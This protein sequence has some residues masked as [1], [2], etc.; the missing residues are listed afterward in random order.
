MRR[1][2]PSCAPSDRTQWWWIILTTSAQHSLLV[3]SFYHS[4]SCFK[5]WLM[6]LQLLWGALTI[7]KWNLNSLIIQPHHDSLCFCK[8]K[9]K[10]LFILCLIF[11]SFLWHCPP[12]SCL[13]SVQHHPPHLYLDL[14]IIQGWSKVS[15][16]NVSP[17]YGNINHLITC[18]LIITSYPK[19]CL[20][21]TSLSYSLNS[22]A[23]SSNMS[24]KSISLAFSMK[25]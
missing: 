8:S 7:S 20:V 1:G 18:L 14:Q 21:P 6:C 23:V 5:F 11:V 24:L 17:D 4:S 19:L 15:C 16:R 2:Y 9:H 12:S 10:N 3:T 13:C 25:T 22:L